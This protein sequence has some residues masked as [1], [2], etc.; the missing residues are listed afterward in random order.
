MT[1]QSFGEFIGNHSHECG[2][3]TPQA[4][5]WWCLKSGKPY[6]RIAGK[7]FLCVDANARG[8]TV[9]RSNTGAFHVFSDDLH[10]KH[11]RHEPLCDGFDWQPQP[12]EN[13]L[14]NCQDCGEFRGHGHECVTCQSI[15]GTPVGTVKITPVESPDDW[16]TQDLVHMRSG[17]DQV[18]WVSTDRSHKFTGDW[19][20]FDGFAI[21]YRHGDVKSHDDGYRIEVRCPRKDLPKQP[22][23]FQQ[24]NEQPVVNRVAVE[25]IAIRDN[26]VI[27]RE[28]GHTLFPG[29]R[30]IYPDGNG[31]W[32]IG[33][34]Q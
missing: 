28:H 12:V 18:R 5:E 7:P 2:V 27:W 22:L 32:C 13:A 20:L 3:K 16:V 14:V 19:K 9:W 31:G 17:I 26:R 23:M 8:E 6:L 11:W 34:P 21:S 30:L 29:E 1:E 4:G 15:P 24:Y 25:L 10:W 33:I